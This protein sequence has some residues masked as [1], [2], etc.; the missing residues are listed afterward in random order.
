MTGEPLLG[1]STTAR[2]SEAI[3]CP[4]R[5]GLISDHPASP[6]V[7]S[8]RDFGM[9]RQHLLALVEQGVQAFWL[10][11]THTAEALRHDPALVPEAVH[12]LP[13]TCRYVIPCQP[14]RFAGVS[15]FC[16]ESTVWQQRPL[17]TRLFTFLCLLQQELPGA[18]WHVWG[19]I[20]VAFLTVYT[21]R[22]LGVPV[23]VSYDS[24]CMH[25]AS[26]L[27]FAGQWV[28]QQASMAMV[29]S[30]ADHERLVASRAYPP[31]RICIC[32]PASASS[33]VVALYQR[34]SD[35]GTV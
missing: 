9:L 18:V 5:I 25:E 29:T 33:A 11:S 35:S 17:H 34:L 8:Q 16:V 27:S 3:R 26:F 28:T 12:S 6:D 10:T 21:A 14:Y 24:T 15:L 1:H 13:A 4:M 31:A 30:A 19:N 23:V 20:S 2:V 7:A 22:F 32:H